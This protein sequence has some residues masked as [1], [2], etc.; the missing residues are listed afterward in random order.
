VTCLLIGSFLIKTGW[1]VLVIALIAAFVL[2]L[3]SW[4]SELGEVEKLSSQ[5][6]TSLKKF[7]RGAAQ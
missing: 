4:W 7:K 2:A 6:R 1:I 5:T 3:R